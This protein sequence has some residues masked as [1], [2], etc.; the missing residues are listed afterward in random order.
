M[1]IHIINTLILN[2]GDAAILEGEVLLFQ[3]LFGPATDI[4]VYGKQSEVAARYYPR[5]LPFRPELYTQVLQPAKSAILERVFA[6]LQ[7]THEHPSV[8]RFY[9]GAWLYGRGYRSL[10]RLL[11]SRKQFIALEEYASADLIVSSGG[12]YLVEHYDLDSKI[13]DLMTAVLLR[14]PL[15]LYTQSLGPFLTTRHRNYLR[16]VFQ[17]AAAVLL[18]DELSREHIRQ[19]NVSNDNLHV[20]ADAAFAL[21]DP[22]RWRAPVRTGERLQVA[23]SVREWAHFRTVPATEGQARYAEAIGALITHLV[24]HHRAQIVFLSTCQG[25]PEYWADDSRLAARLTAALPADVTQHVTVDSGF[26][27]PGT[28]L[29]RL[30]GFDLVIST[31]MHL[32]ILALNAGIPALTIAYEFKSLELFQELGHRRLSHDIE[33]ITPEA[34]IRSVNDVLADLEG[35]RDSLRQATR[36]QLIRVHDSAAYVK[37]AYQR[38]VQSMPSTVAGPEITPSEPQR[39]TPLEGR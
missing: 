19:L 26:H 23:V 9:A 22:Q 30:G 33:S 34:L 6:R 1:N 39:R 12:T 16:A 37:R 4:R 20:T 24:R 27:S 29:D 35:L 13:F 21:A 28:L 5:F 14:K 31:R 11:L 2:S 15:V 36:Q 8:V 3:R 38:Y 32:A 18:R 10:A 17:H 25:I 7:R